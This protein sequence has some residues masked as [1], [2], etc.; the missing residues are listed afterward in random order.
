MSIDGSEN[1]LASNVTAKR[2]IKGEVGDLGGLRGQSQVKRRQIL[3]PFPSTPLRLRPL[4][5]E[6]MGSRGVD[7]LRFPPASRGLR[8]GTWAMPRDDMRRQDM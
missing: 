7:G 1:T 8:A 5:D 2:Q 3:H 4:L 6:R